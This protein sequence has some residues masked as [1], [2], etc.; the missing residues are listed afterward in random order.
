MELVHQRQAER[1]WRKMFQRHACWLHQASVWV[2]ARSWVAQKRVTG[3]L[4]S[5]SADAGEKLRG[6][7]ERATME[8]TELTELTLGSTQCDP[9][10][11]MSRS[12]HSETETSHSHDD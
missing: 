6:L 4:Q 3:L 8:L 10:D 7:S 12:S 5:A 1:G 2:G 9:P 11:G